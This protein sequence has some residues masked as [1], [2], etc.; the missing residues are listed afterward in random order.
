MIG[1]LRDLISAAVAGADPAV[2]VLGPDDTAEYT[3]PD[4]ATGPAVQITGGGY[5]LTGRMLCDGARV[6]TPRALI[7]CSHRYAA[8][9]ARLAQA[10]GLALDGARLGGGVVR[11]DLVSEPL[12]DTT[13][14]SAYRW[15]CTVSARL[16]TT[17]P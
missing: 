9:V 4:T 16:S 15:S 5:G 10:V 8:G 13:D 1:G 2:L 17:R 7:V 11:V 6:Y 14:P 12:E 3:G